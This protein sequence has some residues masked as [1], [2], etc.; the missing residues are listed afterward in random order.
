MWGGPH[1]NTCDVCP[2]TSYL[3]PISTGARK[4]LVDAEHV[5]GVGADA[6]VEVVLSGE[7]SHVLVRRYA[8]GLEGLRGQLLLLVGHLPVTRG[9]TA[10]GVK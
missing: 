2:R 10:V 7:L 1:K 5:E 4:H 6:H 8:S 9:I 3:K